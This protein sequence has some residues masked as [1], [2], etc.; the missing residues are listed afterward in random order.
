VTIAKN[1]LGED[2]LVALNRIVS[3]YLDYAELQ[4]QKR[5]PMHM[6][7][8]TKKLDGFL[9]F[10]EQNILTNAGKVSRELAQEHAEDEFETYEE[11]RR[12][13]EA[14]EPTSDFDKLVEGKLKELDSS[15]KTEKKLSKPR[16][17]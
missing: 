8:W 9:Q 7:D 5:T 11:N 1:Y 10:N 2:E 15:V 6:S 13:I 3:M 14:T 4:A 17:K 16:K 12:Q